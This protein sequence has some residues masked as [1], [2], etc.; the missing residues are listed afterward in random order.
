MEQKEQQTEDQLATFESDKTVMLSR[1]EQLQSDLKEKT[2]HA[3]ELLQEAN[4]ARAESEKI[5]SEKDA[6]Q[7]QYEEQNM[8]MDKVGASVKAKTDELVLRGSLDKAGLLGRSQTW[9]RKK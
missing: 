3:A 5:A 7:K 6:A 4:D 8:D 2:E 1:I 9:K